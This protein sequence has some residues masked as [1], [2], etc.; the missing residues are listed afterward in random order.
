M[1]K[2]GLKRF[3]VTINFFMDEEFMA[4]VPAH[5]TYISYLINKSTIDSYA[6]SM[7]SYRTWIIMICETKAEVQKYLEKAPLYKY[8]TIE[9]DELF[10]YNGQTYRLP[11]LQMN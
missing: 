3:I 1:E 4:L 10:V 9:I 5:R 8:W 6:V 7:E 11:S 2:S